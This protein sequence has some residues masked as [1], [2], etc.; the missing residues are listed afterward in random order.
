MQRSQPT[1]AHIGIHL[2]E[3]H[4]GLQKMENGFR[5]RPKVSVYIASSIDGYIAREIWESRLAQLWPC[6]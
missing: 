1:I 4:L 2:V 5:L 3:F 6:R